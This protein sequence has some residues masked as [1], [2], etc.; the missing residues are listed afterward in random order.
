MDAL[1]L[2]RGTLKRAMKYH[3]LC[4]HLDKMVRL[5]RDISIS[6]GHVPTPVPTPVLLCGYCLAKFP[7]N[8]LDALLEHCETSHGDTLSMC[9]AAD[10]YRDLD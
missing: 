9:V 3:E 5:A 2:H 6:M 8:S 1:G 10:C 4:C 7:R